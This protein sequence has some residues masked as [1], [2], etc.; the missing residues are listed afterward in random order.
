MTHAER[1]PRYLGHIQDAIGRARLY[2]DRFQDV[3]AFASDID[4]LLLEYAS[5]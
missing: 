4:K 2:S 1:I 3:S 5:E